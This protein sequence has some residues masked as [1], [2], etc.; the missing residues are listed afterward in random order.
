MVS[1]AMVNLASL[2]SMRGEP[3]H[4]RSLALEAVA[5]AREHGLAE[6]EAVALQY[7]AARSSNSA[8]SRPRASI[9]KPRCGIAVPVRSKVCWKR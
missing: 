6:R 5:H 3:E 8:R 2:A 4:A 9:S 1:L 7:L